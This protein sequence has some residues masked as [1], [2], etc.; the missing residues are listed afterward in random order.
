MKYI[1][2]IGDGMADDP[3][4]ELGA[5][6]RWRYAASLTLTPCPSGECSALYRRSRRGFNPGATRP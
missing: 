5:G 2:V 6:P 4:Q 1:L 3:L